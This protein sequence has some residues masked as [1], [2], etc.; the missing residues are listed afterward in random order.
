MLDWL[1][2]ILG[3]NYSEEIDKKVSAKI[4]ENFVSRA[5]FNEKNTALKNANDTIKQRDEQL[6]KLKNEAGDV[7]SLR[8][9]ITELQTANA[10]AKKAHDK[11]MLQLRVDTNVDAVLK[12]AGCKNHI[13]AKALMADFLSKIEKI[14]DDGSV[15]G[16]KDEVSRHVKDESS[17]FL[18]DTK[19]SAEFVGV[20][21]G[22]SGNKGDATDKNTSDMTY[23]ELCEFLANN[24]EAD[25]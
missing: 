9:K 25:L 24:P 5:D 13:A 6:E 22:A 23:D 8:S 12:E 7:E 2:E 21:P 4:G 18:F 11:D 20:K 14:E 15:K 3:D 17:S 10:D 19:K 16:L 1:K